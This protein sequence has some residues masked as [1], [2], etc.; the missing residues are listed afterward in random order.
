MFQLASKRTSKRYSQF[1][2]SP[3]FATVDILESSCI[4]SSNLAKH[5]AGNLNVTAA[6]GMAEIKQITKE[7]EKLD[8]KQLSQQRYVPTQKKRD[9]LSTLN[10]GA[11]LERS[12]GRRMQSQ[13]A[14]FSPKWKGVG[15]GGKRMS[16]LGEKRMEE[17]LSEKS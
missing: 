10:L 15:E 11:K 8:N 6:S 4:N 13:D 14:V 12:L 5:P 17:V 2:A 3:S 1:S 16:I 9:E 7:L